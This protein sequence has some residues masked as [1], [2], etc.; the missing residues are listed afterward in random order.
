MSCYHL[1]RGH[2]PLLVHSSPPEAWDYVRVDLTGPDAADGSRGAW[3]ELGAHASCLRKVFRVQVEIKH[4][5][6]R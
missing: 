6:D 1:A 2:L 4:P 3:Q 5:D